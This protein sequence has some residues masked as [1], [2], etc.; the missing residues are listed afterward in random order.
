MRIAKR[1]DRP[2]T[3]V[4][5]LAWLLDRSVPLPGRLRIGLDGILGLIPNVGDTAGA[6][7]AALIIVSAFRQGV[8][9]STI[10]RMLVN[11]GIDALI[12]MVPIAGDIFDFFFKSNS[13]NIK[14]YSEA[15]SG[16]R[17]GVRDTAFLVTLVASLA[18]ILIL[19]LLGLVGLV[20]T[21]WRLASSIF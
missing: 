20:V 19:P 14:L 2:L 7:L 10:T 11:T 1:P 21:T 12:G 15:L 9:R 18:V 8:P 4:E 5:K 16:E 6:A 13:R 17:T 3:F